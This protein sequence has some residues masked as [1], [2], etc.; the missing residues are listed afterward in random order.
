MRA[1]VFGVQ[2]GTEPNIRRYI[3]MPETPSWRFRTDSPT[4][5]IAVPEHLP[6]PEYQWNCTNPSH[7]FNATIYPGAELRY[8]SGYKHV[9]YLII[10]LI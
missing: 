8:D 2:M 6:C 1:S 3:G 10:W 4:R 9:L 7:F 5:A